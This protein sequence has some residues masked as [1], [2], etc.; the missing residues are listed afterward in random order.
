MG[1]MSSMACLTMSASCTLLKASGSRPLW[2]RSRSRMSLISR[3]SRSELVRAMRS[4]FVAFSL[5]SPR[6]P[7]VS[8]PSAPRIEVSGVRSSWLTVEMN[9][10]LSRSRAKRWLISRKLSTEPEERPNLRMSALQ[11]AGQF[12]R[13]RRRSRPS[14]AFRRRKRFTNP[15]AAANAATPGSSAGTRFSSGWTPTRKSASSILQNAS[16]DQIR[17]AARK[18]GMKMLAED[19]WRLVAAGITTV[20]EVLSVTTA[21]EVAAAAKIKS[22]ETAAEHCGLPK[23]IFHAH[24]HLQRSESRRQDCRGAA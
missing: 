18:Q 17:E 16:T 11:A 7:E 4:R 15:S 20:E 22:D 12:R 14:S 23:V 2:I 8:S 19:G 9:S 24:V 21:K 5:V 3:T 6:M 10:S 13:P 1:C